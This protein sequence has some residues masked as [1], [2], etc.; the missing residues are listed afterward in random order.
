MEKVENIKITNCL[1]E[2]LSNKKVKYAI[3]TLLLSGL[4]IA[5]PRIFHVLAGTSA[6]TI[7]LPMHIC[8][9]IAA[10]TFGMISSTV[11]VGS[12]VIF[13]Y[14]LT[15]MPSLTRLPYMFIELAIYAVL[16]SIFNKKFNSY[17]S[18]TMTIVLGRILYAGILFTSVNILGFSSY[19]I[20]VLESVKVG[21]PGIILQ[22][23]FVPV[24]AKIINK[25][26]NLKND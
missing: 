1:T 7:F 22:I 8:V 6:G 25:G 26:L 23:L 13:S 24:I 10:L 5:M 12:S 9:L 14:L 20:S 3:G 16:L 17:I 21:I 18:L 15:G 19:G 2:M 4:G 11:V